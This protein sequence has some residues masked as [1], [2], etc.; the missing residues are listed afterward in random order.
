MLQELWLLDDMENGF[1]RECLSVALKGGGLKNRS[2][3]KVN[4]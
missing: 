4:Q 1:G 2:K 3:R